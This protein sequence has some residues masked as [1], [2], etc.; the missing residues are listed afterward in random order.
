MDVF[1]TIGEFS[2]MTH[3]SVK[4]LR[5]YHDVGVLEPADVDGSSGYR[6]YSATQV[7]TA[8]LIRRLR[9]LDM[10][11][12]EVRAVIGAGDAATRNAAIAAHLV[13]MEHQ[14]EQT[15]ATVASLR[16]LLEDDRLPAPV[17]YRWVAPTPALAIRGRVGF[18]DCDTWLTMAYNDIDAA[19]T[20]A[21]LTVAGAAGAL[22]PTEF[23]E[24]EVGEVVAFVPIVSAR[25]A[26]TGGRVEHLEL[27]AADLAVLVHHGPFADLDRTYGALGTTVAE[28]AIGAPGPIREHYLVTA[29]DTDDESRHRTEVC[30]PITPPS[31]LTQQGASR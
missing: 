23:F 20:A 13:R 2:R 12:D 26:P 22:Y 17:A 16:A 27:A 5:H 15:R 24:A 9:D 10:P 18:D 28:R 31:T 6:R 4:A 19:V 11:L 29:A 3:L 30:W 8:Q 14:L 25:G 7:A 1:V 21:R